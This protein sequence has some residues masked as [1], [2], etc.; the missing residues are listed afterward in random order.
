LLAT[1]D[2]ERFAV[3][4]KATR[5]LE[6]LSETAEPALRKA[7]TD[8]PAPDARRRIG[9][10]LGKLR[11]SRLRPH[12]PEPTIACGGREPRDGIGRYP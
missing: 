8:D 10:L 7:L 3:R 4:Q 6:Q 11:E 5:E 12:V 9:R 1:L 2:D